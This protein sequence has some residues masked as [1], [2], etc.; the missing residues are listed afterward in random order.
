MLISCSREML[1]TVGI[2]NHETLAKNL[3]R[4]GQLWHGYLD[5]ISTMKPQDEG[6]SCR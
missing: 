6:T 4:A 1:L 3:G 2:T 5:T